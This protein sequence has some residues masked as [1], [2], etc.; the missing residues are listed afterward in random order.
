[1]NAP[2]VKDGDGD[3]ALGRVLPNSVICAV[4]EHPKVLVAPGH[5]H[6]ANTF[7]LALNKLALVHPLIWQLQQPIPA[8]AGVQVC[9]QVSE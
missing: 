3:L 2:L 5:A 4:F 6:Q 9:A 7:I 8:R 1:M